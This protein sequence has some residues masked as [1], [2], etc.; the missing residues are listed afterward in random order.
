ML[1]SGRSKCLPTR[2]CARRASELVSVGPP[3]DRQQG[4][5][6]PIVL[7]DLEQLVSATVDVVPGLRPRVPREMLV[8]VGPGI[9][10]DDFA[11]RLDVQEGIEDVGEVLCD[12]LFGVVFAAVDCLFRDQRR[13]NKRRSPAAEGIPSRRR[14]SWTSNQPRP[15]SV[16]PW[17]GL[18]VGQLPPGQASPKRE[19][20]LG[21]TA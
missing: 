17:M 9:G 20:H 3:A 4:V 10:Q 5:H 21:K 7:L 14:K 6:V 15:C 8:D 19:E 1:H 12:Q 11:R 18:P 16:G 2:R 13:C